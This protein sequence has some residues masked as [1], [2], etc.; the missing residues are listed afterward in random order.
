[1]PRVDEARL[2]AGRDVDSRIV[3]H[4]A[5]QGPQT[6]DIVLVVQGFE[7]RLAH[8]LPASVL[9][10]EV[11]ELQ[12]EGVT[13]DHPTQV[14]GRLGAED[15][16]GVTALREE[17]EPTDVV[18]V[19]VADDDGIQVPARQ[20]RD[21]AILGDRLTVALVE[22]AIDQ[23]AG[24]LGRELECGSG[25]VGGGAV[26]VKLHHRRA[27]ALSTIAWASRTRASR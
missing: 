11:C 19:G 23:D 5:K 7:R 27:M 14:E 16:T 10:L 17:R 9:A 25:H 22:P 21:V 20:R 26:E 3:A 4:G 12:A 8:S 15:R 24:A 1:V 6:R 18:E 13:H 2:H